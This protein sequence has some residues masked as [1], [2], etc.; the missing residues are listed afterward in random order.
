MMFHISLIY[1]LV[2]KILS[3][4]YSELLQ[5]S[6]VI[7]ILPL[8]RC[9]FGCRYGRGLIVFLFGDNWG[10]SLAGSC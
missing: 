5:Y 2:C 6:A 4:L 7:D 8:F 1:Q 3:K 10:L 9:Y